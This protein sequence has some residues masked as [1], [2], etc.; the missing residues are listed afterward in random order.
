MMNRMMTAMNHTSVG[1]QSTAA[2]EATQKGKDQKD[3]KKRK[4]GL[5]VQTRTSSKKTCGS[6]K[7]QNS[8]MANSLFQWEPSCNNTGMLGIKIIR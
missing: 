2:K 7:K 4:A 1:K 3:S 6:K 8:A 5:D